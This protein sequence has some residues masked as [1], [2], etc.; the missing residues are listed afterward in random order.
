MFFDAQKFLILIKFNMPKFSFVVL[1]F[2]F[3]FLG[4]IYLLLTELG[5]CHCAQAFSSCI[6]W[7]LL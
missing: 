2:N 6:K 7:G 1:L 4:F 3:F 5:L